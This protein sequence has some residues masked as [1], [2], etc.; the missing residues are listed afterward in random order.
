MYTFRISQQSQLFGG[1]FETLEISSAPSRK[2]NKKKES[3][4]KHF[5]PLS[6]ASPKMKSCDTTV[7]ALGFCM[8]YAGFT[9]LAGK[10]GRLE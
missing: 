6:F 4:K 8:S 3:G 7:R 1:P 9:A 2:K 5:T 10:A